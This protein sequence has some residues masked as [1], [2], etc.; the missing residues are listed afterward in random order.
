MQLRYYQKRLQLEYIVWRPLT[1]QSQI[2]ATEQG[3]LIQAGLLVLI[4]YFVNRPIVFFY[5]FFVLY[6]ISQTFLSRVREKTKIA[7]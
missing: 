3:K 7:V 6:C 4:S 1:N 2:I 5:F